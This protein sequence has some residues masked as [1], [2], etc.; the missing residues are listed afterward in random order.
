MKSKKIIFILIILFLFL[1]GAFIGARMYSMQQEKE[2]QRNQNMILARDNY[3]KSLKELCEK[4]KLDDVEIDVEEFNENKTNSFLRSE[5]TSEKFLRL[6][7][8]KAFEFAKEFYY[9]DENYEYKDIVPLSFY[10]CKIET[11]NGSYCYDY[12]N[13]NM[14]SLEYLMNYATSEYTVKN[15][16]EIYNW[17]NK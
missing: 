17:F 5:I 10:S 16:R 1:I 2:A 14:T 3:K 7:G 15:G 8:K 9:L 11:S 13:K 6:S 4:Y 12:T